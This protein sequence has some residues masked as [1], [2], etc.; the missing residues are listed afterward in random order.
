MA[1]SGVP[2]LVALHEI[3]SRNRFG[4]VKEAYILVLTMILVSEDLEVVGHGKMLV[5]WA[6]KIV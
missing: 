6:I 3:E 5:R 4:Q 1:I 2:R